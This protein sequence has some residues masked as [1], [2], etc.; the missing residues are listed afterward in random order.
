MVHA[1]LII[2]LVCQIVH[3]DRND[4][5]RLQVRFV[6]FQ[7]TPGYGGHFGYIK[8]VASGKIVH[9]SGGSIK[10][11]NDTHLVY[12][13]NRHNSALF[14][15]DEEDYVINHIGGKIWHPCGESANPRNDTKCVLHSDQHA[16]AKFYF[17][18]IS[19]KPISPC[20]SVNL[21]IGIVK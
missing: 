2:I 8:H 9:L 7:G 21:S 4:P 1:T 3:S 10:P 11:G 5:T 6:P 16:A 14:E 20:P 15:F 12:H 17:G 19:G 18:D 13:E